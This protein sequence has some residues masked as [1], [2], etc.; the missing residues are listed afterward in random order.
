MQELIAKILNAHNAGELDYWSNEEPDAFIARNRFLFEVGK[1]SYKEQL[2]AVNEALQLLPVKERERD[3]G[4]TKQA[5]PT[6][7]M[8]H[9]TTPEYGFTLV[10]DEKTV[11]A[12]LII[13]GSNGEQI[14]VP[15]SSED[16][17]RLKE[18]FVAEFDR[19]ARQTQLKNKTK[20]L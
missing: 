5:K 14:E 20:I 4:P 19:D 16:V 3:I 10:L 8:I 13:Q 18:M 11:R 7:P 6:L 17:H 15:V 2:D 9:R 1:L 12:R